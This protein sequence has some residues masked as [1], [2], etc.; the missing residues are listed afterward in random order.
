[1]ENIP[2]SV[3]AGVLPHSVIA[4]GNINCDFWSMFNFLGQRVCKRAKPAI[5]KLANSL[6]DQIQK[7]YKLDDKVFYNCDKCVDSC[8]FK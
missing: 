2:K 1:M 7:R 3:A 5:Q 6:K 8:D 4:H